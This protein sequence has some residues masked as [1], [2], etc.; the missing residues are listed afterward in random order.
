M[1]KTIKKLLKTANYFTYF[2]LTSKILPIKN[3]QLENLYFHLCIFNTTYSFIHIYIDNY[4]SIIE[5]L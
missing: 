2:M 1:Y 3:T 4:C 5:L